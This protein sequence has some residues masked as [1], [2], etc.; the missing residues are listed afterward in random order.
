MQQALTTS[1][2]NAVVN[3]AGLVQGI[4]PVTFPAAR[5][6]FTDPSEYGLSSSP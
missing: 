5:S 4:T 1:T 6:I 3:V 2:E